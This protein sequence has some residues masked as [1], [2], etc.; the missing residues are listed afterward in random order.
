[1]ARPPV[2]KRLQ[3]IESSLDGIM[4]KLCEMSPC[5]PDDIESNST[6]K[7]ETLENEE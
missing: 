3:N 4:N 1:M 7:S 6:E 5:K 2:D